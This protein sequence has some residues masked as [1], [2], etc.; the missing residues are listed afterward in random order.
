[1][2]GLGRFQTCLLGR[3][4]HK[5]T[6][7]TFCSKANFINEICSLQHMCSYALVH[8]SCLWMSS[9]NDVVSEQ[10]RS[11]G[12]RRCGKISDTMTIECFQI[13]VKMHVGQ[14]ARV[15][16]VALCMS[17]DSCFLHQSPNRAMQNMMVDISNLIPE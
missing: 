9:I 15:R 4:K 1:M 12:A 10:D 14:G 6:V 13:N 16:G 17:G 8:N 2:A 3:A 5:V 11:D 7:N